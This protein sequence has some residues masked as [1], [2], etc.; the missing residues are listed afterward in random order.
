MSRLLDSRPTSSE[1]CFRGTTSGGPADGSGSGLVCSAYHCGSIHSSATQVSPSSGG[2]MLPWGLAAS[3][4]CHLVG[5]A[6]VGWAS[7]R[8]I[9]PVVKS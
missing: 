3:D 7:V 6:S 5:A 8:G 9:V 2:A 1:V 4:P